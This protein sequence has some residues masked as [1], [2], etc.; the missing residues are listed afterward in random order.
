M[1]VRT[2]TYE[3]HTGSCVRTRGTHRQREAKSDGRDKGKHAR[4]NSISWQ[5]IISQFNPPPLSACNSPAH[6]SLDQQVAAHV[7]LT[8]SRRTPFFFLNEFFFLSQ[9]RA[10]VKDATSTSGQ[11][12]TAPPNLKGPFALL[13]VCVCVRSPRSSQ[14]TSYLCCPSSASH[15]A[16]RFFSRSWL[17]HPRN[18]IDSLFLLRLRYV[19]VSSLC[20]G[21]KGRVA[22]KGTTRRFRSS[23][24]ARTTCLGT[25]LVPLPE[26]RTLRV[27]SKWVNRETLTTDK[28]RPPLVLLQPAACHTLA[29]APA[30]SMPFFFSFL[31]GQKGSVSSLER[32]KA[33]ERCD[34]SLFPLSVR[35][36]SVFP[37]KPLVT[38][39]HARS[40]PPHPPPPVRLAPGLR[41]LCC[42]CCRL[43]AR[44]RLCVYMQW[45][46]WWWWGGSQVFTV[47]PCAPLQGVQQV[48]TVQQLP[49]THPAFRLTGVHTHARTH[50]EAHAHTHIRK[51]THTQSATERG[52]GGAL[53][54][55]TCSQFGGLL[56]GKWVDF[57]SRG[58]ARGKV[59]HTW[60]EC[61]KEAWLY[62][63]CQGEFWLKSYTG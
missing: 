60:Q 54:P 36:G 17:N 29:E 51:R 61:R 34:Q 19:P 58:E 33:S 38:A 12:L 16:P 37:D 23:A 2:L 52:A 39:W 41:A 47:A 8:P 22:A 18:L 55:P 28:S 24:D 30:H 13:C 20:T 1:R 57:S 3:K 35:I 5:S 26:L 56:D 53:G 32:Q 25:R 63:G 4:G 50:T 21:A 9:K 45:W 40:P 15:P 27:R 59:S 46:W 7:S 14:Q 10:D 44:V 42:C 62:S 6:R 43:Y 48:A 11:R 31:S 49:A